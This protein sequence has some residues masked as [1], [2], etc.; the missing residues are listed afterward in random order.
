MPL[1][2]R[3]ACCPGVIG[4]RSK[5]SAPSIKL[6]ADASDISEWVCELAGC[7]VAGREID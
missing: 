6:W 4:M 2:R 7:D 1:Q 5:P 3:E